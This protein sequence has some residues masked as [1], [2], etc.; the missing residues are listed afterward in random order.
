[1][2]TCAAA[3]ADPNTH[4]SPVLLSNA[5]NRTK[6]GFS[7]VYDLYTGTVLTGLP[8]FVMLRCTC[9]SCTA[10]VAHGTSRNITTTCSRRLS[11]LLHHASPPNIVSRSQAKAVAR[12]VASDA[13]ASWGCTLLG[14]ITDRKRFSSTY[15]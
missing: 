12:G 4:L 14:R 1:M 13:G 7:C 11:G 3:I 15:F 9:R 2:S 6:P 10:V 8:V 5:F